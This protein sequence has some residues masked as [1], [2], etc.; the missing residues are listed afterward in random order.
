MLIIMKHKEIKN[1]P[2]PSERYKKGTYVIKI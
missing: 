2:Y 1:S